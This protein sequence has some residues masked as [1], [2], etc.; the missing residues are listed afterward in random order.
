LLGANGVAGIV[1]LDITE[2]EKAQ[3]GEAAEAIRSKCRELDARR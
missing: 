3:L 1:E 2:E